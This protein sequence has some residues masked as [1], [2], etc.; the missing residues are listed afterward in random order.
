[1]NELCRDVVHA[2]RAL[3]RLPALS[4][5]CIVSLAI[6]IG[7][8]TTTYQSIRD[9]YF[10]DVP[11]VGD[12]AGLVRTVAPVS[13]QAFDAFR[14]ES[15][16]FS[17]V[18]A[19]MA[20]VPFLVT[21][22]GNS[23][24][25]YGHLVTPNYFD[26]LRAPVSG[27]FGS[28]SARRDSIP[29]VIVSRRFWES[30]LGSSS[31]AVGRPLQVNHRHVMLVGVAAPDFLGASPLLEGANLWIPVTVQP[32][33]VPELAS[34]L[35]DDP[36]S[37]RFR[38]IGRLQPG[39]TRQSAEARLDAT[40]SRFAATHH[41]SNDDQPG[42][43]VTLV[44]GG[45]V[46]PLGERERLAASAFPALMIGLL[47]W[48]A[49]SNVAN[50]LLARAA[51]RRRE[52]AVRFALGASRWRVV[53]Q[54]VTESVLLSVAGGVAGL[55]LVWW[56]SA[57]LDWFRPVLPEYSILRVNNDWT[58]L[59]F[60][61]A[62]SVGTG[63][64]FGLAP[65]LQ[66]T[67]QDIAGGLKAPSSVALP[68][69]RW[70]GT[71]NMIVLQQLGAS[72]MLLLLTGF[73]LLG[74]YR[75]AT[76]DLGFN[77]HHLYRMSLDPVREGYSGDKVQTLVPRLLDRLKAEPGVAAAALSMSA[78]LEPFGRPAATSVRL[79][80]PTDSHEGAD[81][82][83]MNR[84][85][86]DRVGAG[87]FETAQI[88]IVQGRAFT[89]SDEREIDSVGIVNEYL[90]RELYPGSA[91]IG[92]SL[93][94]NGTRIEIVGVA[95]DIRSSSVFSLP[96]RHVYL[97]VRPRDLMTPGARGMI[98]LVRVAPG[99]P[100]EALIRRSVA[101]VAPA[102]LTVFDLRSVDDTVAELLSFVRMTLF[103][104]GGIGVF[105]LALAAI[106]LAGVTAHA[107]AQ[108]RCEIGVRMALGARSSDILRLVMREGTW[109]VTVGTVLGIAGGYATLRVLVS[110]LDALAHVTATSASDPALLIGAPLASAMLA[111]LACYLPARRSLAIE[112]A[113]TMRE[114]C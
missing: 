64:L 110:M 26:V 51:S 37:A 52:I 13:Y 103:V 31:S 35:L 50:L 21:V 84:V 28:A 99:V 75:S 41:P 109:I 12:A 5:T 74:V 114:E 85:N 49:G 40:A 97:P 63:L 39:L 27:H 11:G 69:V 93:E 107:V 66:A 61:V 19:Y 42:S 58:V 2:A 77:P 94:L 80:D 89:V 68:A 3:R 87:F 70:F 71:R 34:G 14:R 57:T 76:P 113:I 90:A 20:P 100:A 86:T 91:A 72:L 83:T 29:E 81:S 1:M 102:A 30:R 18:A 6:G 111:M 16:A 36:A 104:Y 73:I 78:P 96:Q 92:R 101:A 82:K 56:S 65:A 9:F 10:A 79:P 112:P 46:M 98:V 53:R 59:A 106:G 45:R 108:R 44:P 22:G 17:D 47:L 25:V 7:S 8:S 43:R 95:R 62:L 48:V 54:L 60:S 105:S 33:L 15:G 23:E 88:R 38:V 4:I 24:R 32:A 55:L 67:R